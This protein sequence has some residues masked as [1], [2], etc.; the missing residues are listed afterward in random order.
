MLPRVEQ[1]VPKRVSHL[2]RRSQET[3]VISVGHDP[4]LLPPHHPIH[5]EC[6]P[7]RDRHHPSPE[8]VLIARFD[9]EVS[10]IAEQRIVHEPKL[11]TIAST[12]ERTLESSH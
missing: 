10:V 8:R 9:D 11:G 7:R 3:C 5:R 1:H 12:S 2:A 6:Q 4:T